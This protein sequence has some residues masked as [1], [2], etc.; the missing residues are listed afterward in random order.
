MPKTTRK[1]LLTS[2]SVAI[3]SVSAF[4]PAYAQVPTSTSEL[5][6]GVEQPLTSLPTKNIV[7]DT[8]ILRT[9]DKVARSIL[10][11]PNDIRRT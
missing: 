7:G 3:L 8:V 5:N 9:L 4:A 6:E 2:L 11:S 1:T 10:H